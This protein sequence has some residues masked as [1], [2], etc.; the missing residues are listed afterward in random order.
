MSWMDKKFVKAHVL[1]HNRNNPNR[2]VTYNSYIKF[3]T[4]CSINGRLKLERRDYIFFENNNNPV[5]L[6]LNR[7]RFFENYFRSKE[8]S[9]N[10]DKVKLALKSIS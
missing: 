2:I 6:L 7:N 8:Y 1:Q 4:L 10:L 5:K 9:D 3:A